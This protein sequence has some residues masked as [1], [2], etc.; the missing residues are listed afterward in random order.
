MR[1]LHTSDWHL[2][3][4]L[5]GVDLTEAHQAYLD[6]LVEVVAAERVDAVLVAG[7]VYDRAIPPTSSITQLSEALARLT[8][9]TRV[10]LTPGNH[11]SAVRLGFSAALLDERLSIRTRVADVARPTILP[12]ADGGV[13]AYVYPLPYLD[14]DMARADLAEAGPD[15]APLLP[16]RSH[17]GVV[18][19]AMGR[20]HADLA[21][22]RTADPTRVPAVL[23]AHAFV[24]GGQ[25]SESERDLR[26]GG[27]EV[28]PSGALAHPEATI[29]YAALGHL[30]GPQRVGG[31]VPARYS[32]SPVA[33][34]F[35]EEHHVKSS[36]LVD[37]GAPGSEPELVEAPVL[38]RLTTLRGTI[39]ELTSGA[40]DHH[41]EDHVR[42][43]VTDAARPAHMRAR[44][45]D[46]LPHLLVLAHEPEG[47][48]P[49]GGPVR[50]TAAEDPVE[51]A[52]QFVADAGGAEATAA[53]RAALGSAVEAAEAMRRS[54]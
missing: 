9:L 34:S 17:E 28:V 21:R 36:V 10:V 54:A 26:V 42:V 41:A 46:H 13:G 2:G 1:I 12:G 7:D 19:A 6:H 38:R 48:V 32:G 15:G 47:A 29:D 25:A 14:P 22:R 33:F 52:A 51:I 44:L 23:M 3:R 43:T 39:D 31:D 5:H 4:T 27:V 37:L 35:S 20:V 53:E 45:L 18:T 24:A 40:F 16:P 50:V 49:L 11:D 8:E 30:H